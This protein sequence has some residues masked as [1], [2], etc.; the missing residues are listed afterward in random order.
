MSHAHCISAILSGDIKKDE[1]V[2]DEQVRKRCIISG[3]LRS[4]LNN[5]ASV[6]GKVPCRT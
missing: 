6:R 4:S 3:K 1:L 5:V 2:M